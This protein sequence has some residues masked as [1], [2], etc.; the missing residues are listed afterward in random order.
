MEAWQGIVADNPL[1]A[2]LEPDVE[3]LLVN[4]IRGRQDYYIAP[5]DECYRLV[6]LIRLGWRGL[7]GGTAVWQ[8]IDEFFAGLQRRSSPRTT[9]ERGAAHA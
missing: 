2:G 1:L 6:G 8:Q 4:R 5:I 9:P 3:A 7:A